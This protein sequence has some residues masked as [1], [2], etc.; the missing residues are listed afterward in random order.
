MKNSNNQYQRYTSS[1]APNNVQTLAIDAAGGTYTLTHSGQTTAAIDWDATAAEV[2]AALELLSTITDVE[3]TGTGDADDPYI[4]TFQNPSEAAAITSTATNLTGGAST[5]TVS[6]AAAAVA[7]ILCRTER[8]PDGT[9][10]SDLPSAMWCHGQW[11][12]PDR[13]VDW[14]TLG[15]DIKAALPTCKFL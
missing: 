3:V 1:T 10:K 8:F 12:R 4:I 6:R 9:I 15:T 2:G 5:A 13:I 11:F 14:A 7:G